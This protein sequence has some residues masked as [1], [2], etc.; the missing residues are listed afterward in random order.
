MDRPPSRFEAFWPFYVSQHMNPVNRRLHAY[1]T[2]LGLVLGATALIWRAPLAAYAAVV[3]AYGFAWIGH[4]FYERNRPATFTYP[5]LS[6]RADLRMYR[7]TLRGEMGA[8]IL[9]LTK[10]L[11][12]LREG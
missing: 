9:L 6:L 3:A 2:S 1:G 7:L 5:L 12:R 8:E 11:N 4:F 10:E